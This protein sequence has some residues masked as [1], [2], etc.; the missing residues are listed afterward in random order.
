MG[1]TADR[2]VVRLGAGEVVQGRSVTFPGHDAQIDLDAAL[3]QHAGACVPGRIHLGNFVIGAE[4]LHHRAVR[5]GDDQN[6]QVADGLAHAPE[7]AGHDHLLD[8]RDTLQKPAQGFGILRRGGE[9]ESLALVGMGLHCFQDVLLG[10]CAEAGQRADAP[11]LRGPVQLFDR[12]HVEIVVQRLDRF[13]P[14]P[15]IFSSSVIAGGSS[16]RKRSSRLQCPVV[17]IS[18]ILAARSVPMPGNRVRS[19]PRSTSTRASCGRSPRMRA[20]LR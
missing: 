14:S 20:A 15:G 19:S 3:E 16:R 7:A 10:L 6:I 2:D 18:L 1:D 4:A 8:T 9:L 17:T 12:L 5:R 13:G 11:V